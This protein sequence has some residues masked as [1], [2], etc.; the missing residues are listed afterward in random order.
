[1]RKSGRRLLYPRCT[2]PRVPVHM[3]N[4]IETFYTHTAHFRFLKRVRSG[5]G[6]NVT[7]GVILNSMFN[8]GDRALREFVELLG[9][10]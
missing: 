3:A 9:V 1:M 6:L 10:S 8:R 4:I 7:E 5:F 2:F